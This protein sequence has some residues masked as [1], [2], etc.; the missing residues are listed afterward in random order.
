MRVKNQI[1]PVQ[2]RKRRMKMFE[3]KKSH[4]TN[5]FYNYFGFK[6]YF[7]IDNELNVYKTLDFP[8]ND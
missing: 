6:C 4:S 5:H 7:R 3:I 8:L 1:T 2:N